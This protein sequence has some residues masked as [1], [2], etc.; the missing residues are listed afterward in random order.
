M[1][2]LSASLEDYLEAIFFIVE[3]KGAARPKDIADR[4]HVKAASVTGA[5]KQLAAKGMVNYAPYDIVTLT[6]PG[7]RIAKG[8]AKKHKALLSFFTNVLDIEPDEAT[9]F[10]CTMEHSIPDHVLERFVAFAE[11]VEKCPNSGAIWQSKAKGY[12][13][14]AQSPDKTLCNEC[15][16]TSD[17]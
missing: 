11:F 7:K 16:L 14:R 1:K 4:L 17:F 6:A 12:F 2:K 10:A 5:L 15:A 9:D 3:E 13:C 8:I